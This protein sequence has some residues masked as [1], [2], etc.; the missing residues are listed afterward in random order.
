MAEPLLSLKKNLGNDQLLASR[1]KKVKKWS[2]ATMQ[3]AVMVK[4]KG[5]FVVA[6]FLIHFIFTLK[7]L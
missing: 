5:S 3:K 1:G 6:L 4:T 7:Y 2:K